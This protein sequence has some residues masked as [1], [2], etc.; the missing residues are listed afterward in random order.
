M[1]T[2]DDQVPQSEVA[3]DNNDEGFPPGFSPSIKCDISVTDPEKKGDGMYQYISYK[4]NTTAELQP[5]KFTQSAVVRR[6]SDFVWLHEQLLANCK[7][8]LI[9]PLPEK[10]IIGRFSGDFINE[11]RRGLE[12]FLHRVT[13]HRVLKDDDTV[14]LFLLGDDM[15]MA[16]AREE[17]KEAVAVVTSNRGFMSMFKESVQA[18]SNTFGAGKERTKSDDDVACDAIVDYSNSLEVSL[19]SVHTNVEYL[20]KRT[21]ALAKCW[22]EFGLACTL[23]GQHETK[24]DEEALGNVFSKLGNCADRLSVLIRKRVDRENVH[25]REP[26]KDYIRMVGAVKAMMRTR[27]AVLLTY[28]TALSSLEAKQTKLA[29]LKGVAGKEDQTIKLEQALVEAQDEVDEAK[30]ELDKVTKIALE[31]TAKFREMKQED[32]KK[33]VVEFVRLQIDHSKK[34][35]S[36]WESILPEIQKLDN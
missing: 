14:Q 30:M 36:A 11:R 6:F 32:L 31:E 25:F 2:E 9:P 24:Q 34:V 7:G 13:T 23:L 27:A 4:V 5:G 26:I 35:Q 12:V 20:I 16:A 15:S 18:I 3:G 19:T 28:Q 21:R 22:F 29:Q 33:I 8:V 1:A 17:K 10:A